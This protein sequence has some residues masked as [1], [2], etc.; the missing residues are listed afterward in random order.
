MN[1]FNPW[2]IEYA[3]SFFGGD[4]LAIDLYEKGNRLIIKAEM[5]GISEKDVE[6]LE[7]NRYLIIRTKIETTQKS[8]SPR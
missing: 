2:K 3:P 7:Q 6:V 5:P 1:I 8:K 4:N